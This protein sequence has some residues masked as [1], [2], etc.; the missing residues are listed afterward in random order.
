MAYYQILKEV[1]LGNP[2]DWQICFQFGIYHYDPGSSDGEDPESGYRFIWRRENGQLQG[3]RGQ[4]RLTSEWITELLGKA[5]QAGWYPNPPHV[6]NRMPSVDFK[7][8]SEAMQWAA[9]AR[10]SLL[11]AEFGPVASAPDVTLL[12]S[13][14]DNLS[15]AADLEPSARRQFLRTAVNEDELDAIDR[16]EATATAPSFAPDTAEGLAR[17]RFLELVRP[18]A[19]YLRILSAAA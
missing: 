16:W 5:A 8:A 4:A 11:N 19:A 1:R 3:A 6:Q 7:A 10:L 18:L 14:A 12:R 9:E 15:K 13:F 17:E 2:G